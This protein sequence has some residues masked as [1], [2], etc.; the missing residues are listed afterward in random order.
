MEE[1][2]S[3]FTGSRFL[4][5]KNPRITLPI[6]SPEKAQMSM[7]LG[8]VED[9]SNKYCKHTYKNYTMLL[10]LYKPL[11]KNFKKCWNYYKKTQRKTLQT[12]ETFIQTPNENYLMQKPLYKHPMKTI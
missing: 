3:L 1:V 6:V 11:M 8:D 5:A 10:T 4:I 12:L 2:G 9:C 7:L